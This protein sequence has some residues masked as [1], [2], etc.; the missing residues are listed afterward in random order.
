MKKTSISNPVEGLGYVKYCSSGVPD[1][2][3]KTPNY[4]K[5]NY[6][7]ICVWSRRHKTT[8]K[9]DKRPFF[10]VIYRFFL[11]VKSKLFSCSG[12]VPMRQLHPGIYPSTLTNVCFVEEDWVFVEEGKKQL[13]CACMGQ[14]PV[15]V[16]GSKDPNPFGF[17]MSCKAFKQFKMALKKKKNSWYHDIRSY[18]ISVHNQCFSCQIHQLLAKHNTT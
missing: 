2:L 3:K 9:S 1:L 18:S 8:L 14:I 12:S 4:V 16:S 7:K 11:V 17:L 13:Q 10:Y 15:G 5:Y 6:H